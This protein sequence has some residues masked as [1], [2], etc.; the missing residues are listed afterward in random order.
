MLGLNWNF[1]MLNAIYEQE[2]V[3][4]VC[5]YSNYKDCSYRDTHISW[6]QVSD[7]VISLPKM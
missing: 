6:T 4:L 1:T 3:S 7:Q 5:F 2:F